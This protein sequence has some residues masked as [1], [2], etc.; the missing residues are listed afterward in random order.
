[1]PTPILSRYKPSQ[2]APWNLARVVHLHRRAGL[3]ANWHEVQRDL[4][5]GPDLAVD[6]LLAGNSPAGESSA[7]FH[8]TA[9]ALSAAAVA[10]N[11]IERLKASWIYRLLFT[12]DPLGERL[13]LMWHNHFATSQAK[14]QDVALMLRQNQAF[15]QFA[16]APFGE[17]LRHVAKD[18]AL[19]IWLDADSNRQEH[20]NENLAREIMELFAL[21]AGNYS[22][23]D[24]KEAARA[25]TGWTVKNREFRED[26]RYHD[27]DAK[28]IFAQRGN[29]N[30]DDLLTLLLE[31]PA[32]ARRLAFR[33]CE[34]FLGEGVANDAVLDE[35]ADGMRQRHLDVGWGVETLLR[36]ELF[37]SAR[38]F[39]NRILSPVEFVIGVARSLEMVDPPPS[40][41]L[42]AEWMARLGQDLFNPPNVFGWPGGRSWLTSRNLI[43]RANFAAAIVAGELHHPVRPFDPVSFARARGVTDADQQRSFYSELLLGRARPSEA[44]AAP[45]G[46]APENFV[47]MI[48][49]SPEAQLA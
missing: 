18:P 26:H 11:S 22:E 15:R 24:I 20:P 31:H 4:R 46:A 45:R 6:R 30:G 23:R 35:L 33:L 48:L 5:E 25:L 27:G 44:G 16:R 34:M 2:T 47:T 42:L 12:P 49:A 3:A 37:F 9:D 40:S 41:L 32:T 36:S 8:S 43:G 1:M 39:G 7:E 13:T 21:A 14:V 17:M 19:L 38:N 28:T 10:A 29:W